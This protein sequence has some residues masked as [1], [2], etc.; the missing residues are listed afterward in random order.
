MAVAPRVFRPLISTRR[1]PPRSSEARSRLASHGEELRREQT[2]YVVAL[3]AS[4]RCVPLRYRACADQE[5]RMCQTARSCRRQM[6]VRVVVNFAAPE[7]LACSMGTIGL[8]LLR[9]GEIFLCMDRPLSSS[10]KVSPGAV[11]RLSASCCAIAG[12]QE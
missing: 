9:F 10:E 1:W 7:R 3:R 8:Q 5:T 2:Q 6:V 11:R 4:P 12:R